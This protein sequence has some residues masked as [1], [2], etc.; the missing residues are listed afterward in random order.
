MVHAYGC[1]IVTGSQ[2]HMVTTYIKYDVTTKYLLTTT[3][4][5]GIIL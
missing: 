4:E 2:G 1:Y 5:C 3:I